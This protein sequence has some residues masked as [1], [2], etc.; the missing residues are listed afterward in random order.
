M[1]YDKIVDTKINE[2]IEKNIFGYSFQFNIGQREVIHTICVNF[3][4]W[5]NGKSDIDSVVLSAPT[6]YGKSIIAM[7]SSKVLQLLT[8]G[9]YILTVDLALQQQ[10]EFD[11]RRNM[12]WPL[13]TIS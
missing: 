9:G 2:I 6:G 11:F 10:Y 12:S 5:K 3:L 4:K 8:Y 1:D 13:C 7:F